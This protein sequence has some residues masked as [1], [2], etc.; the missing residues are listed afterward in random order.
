MQMEQEQQLQSTAQ[1]ILQ[2]FADAINATN[3]GLSA[4]V[5]RINENITDFL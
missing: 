4:N 3:I 2:S 1:I 5:V